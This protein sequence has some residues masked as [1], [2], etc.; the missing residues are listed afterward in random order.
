M[1]AMFG[2]LLVVAG[3]VVAIGVIIYVL[4]TLGVVDSQVVETMV[5]R[6]VRRLF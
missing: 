4:G 6:T 5:M 3:F 2:A 1:R